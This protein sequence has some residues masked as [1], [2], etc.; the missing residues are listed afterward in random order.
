MDMIN[1]FMDMM[2]SFD[3]REFTKI[4]LRMLCDIGVLKQLKNLLIGVKAP[5]I[6]Q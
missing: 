1:K 5:L 6:L 4:R 2:I 3:M